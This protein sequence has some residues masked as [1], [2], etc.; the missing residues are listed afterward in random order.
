MEWCDEQVQIVSPVSCI[1]II[2]VSWQSLCTSSSVSGNLQQERRSSSL[3]VQAWS[4]IIPAEINQVPK[5][6]GAAQTHTEVCKWELHIRWAIFWELGTLAWVLQA[7]GA[8]SREL[9]GQECDQ[10][11][12]AWRSAEHSSIPV[13]GPWAAGRRGE[14]LVTQHRG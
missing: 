1:L 12:W 11:C 2:T 4:H 7:A 14:V 5:K 3:K 9:E 13:Q 10:E 6:F 8:L